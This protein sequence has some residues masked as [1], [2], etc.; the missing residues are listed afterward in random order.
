MAYGAP[1]GSGC[2]GYESRYLLPLSPT[3]I[4]YRYFL[5]LFPIAI[6]SAYLLSISPTTI[7]SRYLLPVSP[8]AI[9][10]RYCLPFPSMRCAVLSGLGWYQIF[11]CGTEWARPVPDCSGGC[12]MGRV[13]CG[14]VPATASRDAHGCRGRKVLCPSSY[15]RA[16]R[17]SV[18]RAP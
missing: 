5:P 6:S 10:Y 3:F 17:C 11:A 7:S 13:H 12:A 18:L 8:T 16:M 2:T 9:P 15:A 4:S 14:V 1:T